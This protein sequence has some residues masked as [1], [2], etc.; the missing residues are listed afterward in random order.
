MKQWL[1]DYSWFL[2]II[3]VWIIHYAFVINITIR[4]DKALYDKIEK[5]CS[6]KDIGVFRLRGKVYACFPIDE[7][8]CKKQE[9][10]ND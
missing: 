3:V 4:H 7:Q 8:K 2:F 6:D 10:D 5:V 9:Q 1:K